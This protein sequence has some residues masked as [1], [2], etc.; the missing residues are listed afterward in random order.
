MTRNAALINEYNQCNK[1]S[2]IRIANGSSSQVKGIGL[3]KISR[4][5][6]LNSILHIPKLDCNLISISKLTS[7]LNCVAKFF[8]NLCIFQDLDT[9]KRIGCAKMCSGLYLLNGFTPQ[10]GQT[11]NGILAPH[12]G[13]SVL[14]FYVNKDSDVMLRHYR[15]GHPNFM[16]LEK[17]V[18]SLFTNKN[19]KSFKCEVCQLSKHIRNNYPTISYKSSHPFVI[20]HSDPFVIIHSDVWG[21]LP[22]KNITGTRWFVSFVDDHTRLT[23]LFIMKEKSEVGQIFQNF[24]S[25]IQTQFHTKIQILKTDNAKEYF[26]SE[27]NTYCLNQGILHISSC[28]NTPQQN[29]VAEKKNRYLFEVAGSLM[30]TTH[31]P[32][33]FWREVVLTAT[34]LINRMPS[35]VLK[36]KIPSQVLLQAFPHT[37]ILSSLDPKVFGCSVFVHIHPHHRNKL[38]PKS[39]KCIFLGYSP[40]QRVQVLFSHQQKV[41]YLNGCHIL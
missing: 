38:D 9:G 35:R 29:R 16:Y 33:Q 14:N 40:H 32:K 7:D 24:H 19:A 12:K 39:I 15:L 30:F 31:V 11:Q 34:Y 18:P 21:P 22:V 17:L 5:M 6:L 2:T 36:F 1:T 3:S 8:P 20:I 13:Q 25:M 26:N 4:G 28:V 27:L 10:K 41:L 23:W 37:K